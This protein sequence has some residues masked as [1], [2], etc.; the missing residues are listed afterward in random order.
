M[1]DLGMAFQLEYLLLAAAGAG[2]D[3]MGSDARFVYYYGYGTPGRLNLRDVPGS[4]CRLHA[5]SIYR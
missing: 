3:N 5:G 4:S 2:A 1:F